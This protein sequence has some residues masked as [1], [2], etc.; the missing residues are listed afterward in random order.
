MNFHSRIA[1]HYLK[2]RNNSFISL[3]SFISMA[4]IAIGV[5]ALIVVISVMN[6]FGKALE[7]RVIG[8]ESQVIVLN[9]GGLINNYGKVE[10][11]ISSVKGVKGISPFIY[12][13]VMASSDSTST[14]SVLRGIDFKS[15]EN[16]TSLGRYIIAGSL[17]GLNSKKFNGIVLGQVLAQ[18]LGVGVGDSVTIVSP[19]GQV[20][21][22]GVLPKTEKFRVCGIIDSGMYNYDSTF[23]FISV[24]NAQ[25]FIGLPS[26]SVTGIEVKLD[27]LGSAGAYAKKIQSLL[28]GRNASSS[29]YALSW[30]ELNKNLFSAIKLEK[31]TM[32]V[33]LSLIVLVA[34]F[35]I[36]ST[37]IMVVMEKK[38]DIAVLK[39]IGASS[40]DITVIF[41][42]QG[43]LIGAIGTFLG[44][45]LGFVIC[46]VEQ[47]YHIISLPSSVYYITKLPV[48]MSPGEFIIIGSCS[49]LLSLAATLYPSFKAATIDPAEGVR[50]E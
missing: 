11:K 12:T 26:G 18:N 33:I 44:L 30:E 35:N 50:Y 15:E 23:S 40:L 3:L 47:V 48:S 38:K 27:R 6:G 37:L 42:T 1:F 22:F 10:K 32:F 31:L 8:I 14:G 46:R 49:L 19:Q 39:S 5:M 25:E 41:M 24:K 17:A 36:I 34:A 21:P 2:P 45:I 13:Y 9:Y 7:K 43:V 28:N 29:F 4:G 20:T 16:V